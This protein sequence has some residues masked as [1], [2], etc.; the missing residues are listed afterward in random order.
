MARAQCIVVGTDYSPS[1]QNALEYSARLSDQM[2]VS[3]AVVHAYQYHG[4]GGVLST[5]E[6]Q[7]R[8]TARQEISVSLKNIRS[9]FPGMKIEEVTRKGEAEDVL[10]WAAA[11]YKALVL[12]VGTQGQHERSDIFVGKTTG[13]LIKLG[14]AP[15]LAVPG[16]C[17][18]LAYDRIVFAVKNAH[19]GSGQVLEP[20]I[21]M[22]EHF[23]SHVTLL[24][25]TQDSMPDLSRF[26]N[27]Y[28]IAPHTH[29][30]LTSDSDNIYQSV[31][32]YLHGHDANLLVVISRLRGFFE[33]LFAQNI[34]SSDTFNSALPILVLHGRIHE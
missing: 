14:S 8:K 7:M 10:L 28:A 9:E 22:Q 11:K 1:G 6:R 3:M 21:A 33:G 5:V 34:M 31:A 24:H 4:K 16:R 26:P 12:V 13:A 23:N 20:L 2:G 29:E 25:V 15:V 27:P 18:Y 19:V 32:D 17:T 30:T